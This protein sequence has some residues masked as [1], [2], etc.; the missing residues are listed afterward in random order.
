MI[1]SIPIQGG[2]FE[3][4]ES[5]TREFERLYPQVDVTQTLREIRGWCLAN[6]TKRK[7]KTGVMRFLNSWMAREQNRGS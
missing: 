6:P 4:R 1:E 7:T 2:E 5:A 3:V